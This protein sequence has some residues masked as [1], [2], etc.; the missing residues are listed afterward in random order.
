MLSGNHCFT[1]KK[2]KLLKQFDE[3]LPWES[4][5]TRT[6]QESRQV[7]NKKTIF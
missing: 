6:L 2:V 4:R 7:I 3:H 5:L 1:L